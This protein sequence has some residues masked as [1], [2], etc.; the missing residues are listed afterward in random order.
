MRA[1]A[2]GDLP[3]WVAMAPADGPEPVVWAFFA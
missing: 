1:R 3:G 2:F